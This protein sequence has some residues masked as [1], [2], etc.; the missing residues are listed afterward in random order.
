MTAFVV[1]RRGFTAVGQWKDDLRGVGKGADMRRTNPDLK[2]GGIR[3]PDQRV[4]VFVSST[5]GELAAERRGVT[6]AIT[7]LRLTPVLFELGARP[8]APQDLYRAYLKQSDIFIGIYAESYGWVA[9]GMEVSGLEDEYRLSAGKPRLIYVKDAVQRQPQLTSFLGAI[10]AEGVVSYR[11][12]KDADELAALVADDLAL[13]LTER[14]VTPPAAPPVAPLP[15]PRWPLVDRVEELQTVT[16]LLRQGDVGLVML[17]GPGGVGKTALALA[18]AHAVA[19]QF[20][21]GASFVSLETLTDNS[22]VRQTVAQQLHVPPLTGQPVEES[23]QAY[24]G[25]RRMLLLLDNVERLLAEA[26]LLTKQAL[27]QAPGLKVLATSREPLRLQGE[28][29]VPVGPLALPEVGV[30]DDPVRLAAV[31]AVAFFLAWR[32][33]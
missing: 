1:A 11:P 13:L 29:V 28:K 20:E 33:P 4:R 30:R 26:A 18:A 9:P 19:D 8:Y 3:T 14:F 27:E 21:D 2:T 10:E 12:F 32:R 6:A 23:L 31:P 22:L 25:P 5:L 7:Q 15:A 24:F 17:T 16:G